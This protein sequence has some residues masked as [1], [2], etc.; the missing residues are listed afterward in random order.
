VEESRRGGQRVGT[1]GDKEEAFAR[2][3]REKAVAELESRVK[4]LR[5]L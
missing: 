2:S 3:G 4:A 1:Q 5:A